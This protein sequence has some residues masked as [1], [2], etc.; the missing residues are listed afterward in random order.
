MDEALD[1]LC[2]WY[3]SECNGDWEQQYG[4]TIETL[5]NPGWAVK[6]DL[7]DTQ[8][9]KKRFAPLMVERSDTDWYA[10][11]L[12]DGAFYGYG[13]PSKLGFLLAGFR[14]YVETGRPPAD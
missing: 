6:I 7:Q 12:K 10:F 14:Q 11:E 4:I 13:D 8:V 3:A 5:D 2:R 1:W 9:P